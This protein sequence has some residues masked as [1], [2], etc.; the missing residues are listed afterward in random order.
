MGNQEIDGGVFQ[1]GAV[2]YVKAFG[3]AEKFINDVIHL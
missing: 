2:G 1:P 3:V